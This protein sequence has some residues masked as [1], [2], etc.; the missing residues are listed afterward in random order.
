MKGIIRYGLFLLTA[1][2]CQSCR[3]QPSLQTDVLVVGGGTAGTAAALQSARLGARTMIAEPNTWLGG[4]LSAAGVSAIDGNHHL[5][6][7]IWA[8]FRTAIYTVYGGPAKVATGWVSHTQFEP[9]VADSILKSFAAQLPNLT[10]RYRLRFLEAIVE[11]KQVK[12]AAFLDLSTGKTLAIRAR[13][14]IDATE[15][16]DVMASAGIPYDLGMEASEKTGEKLN[17]PSSNDIIQDMTYAAILKDYGPGADRTIPKPAGF[18]PMEFDCACSDVCSDTA[19]LFSKVDKQKMLDYGKLPNGKYMINWP[20]HGNDIYLNI[21]RMNDAERE[22]ALDKARQKTLR[23]IYYI[24]TVLGFKHIGLADDE[25]PTADKLPLMAYHREGRRLRGIVRLNVNHIADPYNQPEA[26]YRTGI[27]V[28]DYPIDHHHRENPAAPQHLGF[29]PVPSYNIPLGALIPAE[30][31][32]LVVT[33]KCISVSNAANGTTRLQPVVMLTG[34]A[35]GTL[36]ALAV[37]SSRQPREVPVRD[38]Q[39]SLLAA[40]A[41][42]MPYYDV[43]PEQPWFTAAHKIGASGILKGKGE[44]FQ[45]ANRTWFYPDS[46]VETGA[47]TR[48]I[49]PFMVLEP[50]PRQALTIGEACTLAM[51]MVRKYNVGK[52]FDHNSAERFTAQVSAQWPGWGL[53]DFRAERN[54]TRSEFAVLLDRTVDPFTLKQV[55]HSGQFQ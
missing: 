9:R 51:S 26:L 53:K 37:R 29:Y 49:A 35:A 32:G 10:V 8:E 55:N 46:L 7:G 31:D 20:S 4:M 5:P 39:A 33:E 41:Y 21:V 12:G 17:I 42:I 11:G 28:G 54:I 23:F 3:A 15:L 43:K 6:S 44:P 13:Q 19:K 16:G 18:D 24:Q 22:I 27:S 30:A 50:F 52:R 25:F 14:V 1:W 34:Q 36:A 38:V 47:L 48:D 2:I 40:G 45:W